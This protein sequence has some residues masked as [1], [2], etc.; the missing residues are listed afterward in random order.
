M[1]AESRDI[2][3]YLKKFSGTVIAA[4]VLT[5]LAGYIYF[6]Q[7]IEPSKEK[8]ERVFPVI[9]QD[10]IGEIDLKYPSYTVLCRKEGEGW[11]IFKGSTKFKADNKII[12]SMTENI[13]QMKVEKIVSEKATNLAEFGLD[14]PQVEMTVK[15]PEKEYSIVIGSESPIS[16]GT[17]IRTDNS[18]ILLVGGSS[19]DGFLRKSANDLRDKQILS[20]AEDK[21]NRLNFKSKDFSLEVEK[22][23]GKWLGKDLPEYIKID[24]AKIGDLVKT[25]ANL[26][27]DNFEDDEAK[28]LNAYGLDNPSA[29]IELFGDEKPVR[30]LFGNKKGKYRYLKFGSH[31]LVY[32]ISRS[33][34]RQ[35]PRNEN[36]IRAKKFVELDNAK[37]SA[38]VIKRANAAISILKKGNSWELH[39]HKDIKVEESKI[40]EFLDVV[41]GLEVEK[42]VDD[43]P[44]DLAPYG[45]NNPKIEI[46][47]SEADKKKTLLFGDKKYKKVYA[48]LADRGSVYMLNDDILSKI[49][50]SRDELIKK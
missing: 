14:S 21:I 48:K 30:I 1:T 46:I 7:I 39:D 22:K 13:S 35:V 33:T 12:S 41:E 40:Q 10:Q 36:D 27:I 18:R 6:F 15:T 9:K 2:K 42:F 16:S 37:I 45:L 32:S 38:I 25:F 5:L 20:V 8:E 44:S 23:G 19:V 50:S 28:N 11:F 24:Q 26:K 43:K 4:F 17:Y 3:A 47:I 34:F 29:E 31:E 49:P